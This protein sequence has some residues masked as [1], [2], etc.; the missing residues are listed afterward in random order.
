MVQ[1]DLLASFALPIVASFFLGGKAN[2][3]TMGPSL[4]E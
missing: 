1:A 3:T 4:G 2:I